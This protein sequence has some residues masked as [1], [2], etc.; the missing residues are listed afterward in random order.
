VTAIE[1]QDAFAMLLDSLRS[2]EPVRKPAACV[3]L[4][5][6]L[7]EPAPL[8]IPCQD[9]GGTGGDDGAIEGW[10]PCGHCHGSG[11]E[12]VSTVQQVERAA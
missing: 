11:V 12:P 6:E 2:T 1:R 7:G 8:E 4:I 10:E 3:G 5:E 9:C